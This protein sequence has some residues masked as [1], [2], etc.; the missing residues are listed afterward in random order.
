MIHIL[1]QVKIQDYAQFIAV[2]TTKGREMRQQHGCLHTQ[3][4]APAD[5]QQLTILFTWNSQGAF[6]GFLTDPMARETMKSSG[7]LAP[8]TFTFLNK[9]C[10]LPG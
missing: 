3:V 8:P 5:P 1:A 4:F 7:T 10:E 9:I 6:E 2:F